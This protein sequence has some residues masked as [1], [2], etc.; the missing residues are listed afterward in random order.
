MTSCPSY[1]KAEI[2]DRSFNYIRAR[3]RGK[4]HA[5]SGSRKRKSN[6]ILFPGRSSKILSTKWNSSP[7]TFKKLARVTAI[8]S[9]LFSQIWI[10][11]KC[12]LIATYSQIYEWIQLPLVSIA[13]LCQQLN[14]ALRLW[15]GKPASCV[16]F[17]VFPILYNFVYHRIENN[18]G[19][20]MCAVMIN[21]KTLSCKQICLFPVCKN[22]LI[23][24]FHLSF[25]L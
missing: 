14:L 2:A 6:E 18:T 24:P 8:Y 23:V 20:T 10:L 17:S 5:H 9:L 22:L 12:F 7:Y 11:L 4:R 25:F 21:R 15:C 3:E 16:P 1:K 13:S 19:I